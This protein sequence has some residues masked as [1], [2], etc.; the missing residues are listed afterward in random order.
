MDQEKGLILLKH[1][2]HI[3][4]ATRAPANLAGLDALALLLGMLNGYC[5]ALV[6]ACAPRSRT[7][8]RAGSR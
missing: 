1:A 4:V 7:G 6:S 8:S 5:M 3:F 2:S